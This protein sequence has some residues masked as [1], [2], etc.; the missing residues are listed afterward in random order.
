MSERLDAMTVREHNGKKYWTKLGSAFPARQGSGYTLVLDA[1]PA[2]LDGQ[3]RIILTEPKPREDR[4]QGANKGGW[5]Q[6]D[7]GGDQIP[8]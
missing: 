8:F 1:I 7:L 5:G 4:Q 3:Y 6:D 2:S